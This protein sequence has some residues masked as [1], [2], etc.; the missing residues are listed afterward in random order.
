[1][2]STL[3]N[4]V[5][6]KEIRLRFRSS[7]SYIGI[8]S[9]LGILGLISLGFIGLTLSYDYMGTF[10]PEESRSMFLLIS[11]LQL[12]L[13]IFITPGLTA[14]VISSERE[15]Q[16]LPILLTTAQSSTAIILSKLISS[17]SFLL[18]IVF[19]TA[20]LY[21]IV[22]LYGGISPSNVVASFSL[23]AF[24]M[25]VI[26]SFGILASTIIRK[27]IL[28]MVTTY[29][30]A[31]FMTGGLAIITLMLTT[32][33]YQFYNQGT[34]YIWPFLF[35]SLNIPIMFFSVFEPSV[36]MEFQSMSGFGF[37]P[38]IIFFSFYSLFIVGC[39]IIAIRKLRPNMKI[40]SKS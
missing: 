34:D 17:L 25:L 27:T 1:M 21:M 10:R 13:V 28:A 37:S 4:P 26:G 7:K 39:L 20:P 14:G 23:Y 32:F 19:A 36:M 6:N 31:F 24:A 16:T 29:S 5:L 11:M 38:W 22:F 8:A 12:A 30:V 3:I 9:Y 15:R 40:K 18:L 33:S 2:K 35:A